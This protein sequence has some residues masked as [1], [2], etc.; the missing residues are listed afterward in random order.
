MVTTAVAPVPVSAYSSRLAQRGQHGADDDEVEAVEQHR[1]PAQRGHP[2]GGAGRRP[3]RSRC[4][5]V[6]LIETS[7]SG[8]CAVDRR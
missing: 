6:V 3:G 4:V 7:P 5:G 1:D 2:A 8:G